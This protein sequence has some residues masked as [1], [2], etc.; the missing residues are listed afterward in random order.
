MG[1]LS[2]GFVLLCH[3]VMLGPRSPVAFG[4]CIP[5]LLPFLDPWLVVLGSGCL[6]PNAD[7]LRPLSLL[8]PLS[9]KWPYCAVL[10]CIILS[11]LQGL[12]L[13][14]CEHCLCGSRCAG[15]NCYHY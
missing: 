11:G 3:Q 5:E 14:L 13:G 6:F 10:H 9:G 8:L 12:C 1:L 4:F 15:A 2:P 7:D